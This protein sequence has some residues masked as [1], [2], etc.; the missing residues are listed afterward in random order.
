LQRLRRCRSQQ[1]AFGSIWCPVT[2]CF[3]GSHIAK[4]ARERG[5]H[6]SHPARASYPQR[7]RCYL[8]VSFATGIAL[9]RTLCSRHHILLTTVFRG[10]PSNGR[11]PARYRG[12]RENG[13]CQI[14]GLLD[15]LWFLS[16]VKWTKAED[17][18]RRSEVDAS[19]GPIK[20][21]K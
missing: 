6:H 21:R 17:R 8:L 4:H 20:S 13:I 19:G 15:L 10:I 18:G 11:V 1:D 5:V 2:G 7:H 14:V 9:F 12:P 16:A 3:G